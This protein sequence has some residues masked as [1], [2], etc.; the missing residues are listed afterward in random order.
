MSIFTLQELVWMARYLDLYIHAD[1]KVMQIIE[2]VL[3][4]PL[5]K[6]SGAKN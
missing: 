1:Q 2:K 5:R 6:Q 3:R 4:Q